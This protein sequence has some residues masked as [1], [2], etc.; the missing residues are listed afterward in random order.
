MCL[1]MCSSIE[2]S[3]EVGFLAWDVETTGDS[4]ISL[5]Q[6]YIQEYLDQKKNF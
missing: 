2:V 1:F 3:I 5:L 6:K 4:L